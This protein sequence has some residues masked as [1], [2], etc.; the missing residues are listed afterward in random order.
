MPDHNALTATSSELRLRA[1]KMLNTASPPEE[2]RMLVRELL[3]H[4]ATLEA[5]CDKLRQAQSIDPYDLAPIGFCTIDSGGLI[6]KANVGAATLLG[7]VPTALVNR[8]FSEF[9]VEHDRPDFSALK[10]AL[11][12]THFPQ[13]CELRLQRADDTTCWVRIEAIPLM[14]ENFRD[15]ARVMIRDISVRKQAEISLAENEHRL[16]TLVQTIPDLVWLKDTN[17]IYLACNHAFERFFGAKQADIVGKTDYDF[18][19]KALADFFL[20]HDRQ[21][22]ALDKPSMNEEWLTFADGGYHG[23][24]ETIKTPVH[25]DTGKVIGVLGI[26]RDITVHKKTE[27]DLE[28]SKIFLETLLNAIP[29]PIFY[30]DTEGRYLG[31]NKAFEDLFG[32]EKETLVG[33]SVF[34]IAPKELAE[35]YHAK[36][37]EVFQNPGTQIY[38]SEAQTAR[39]EKRRVIFHKAPFKDSTGT[40]AG[41]IGAIMDITEQKHAEE[42]LKKTQAALRASRDNN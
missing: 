33:K 1:E 39:G 8:P 37:L 10:S 41:L 29:V 35:T 20:E 13:T 26:A 22:M 36:D 12:A 30:K 11:F 40:I 17:G 24:F 5:E 16:R 4:T 27:T 25:D 23:L 3:N 2:M 15:L 32:T 21:A 9:V 6:L 7:S 19:D 14:D 38:E 18:V 28:T 42:Q 34:D 31:F